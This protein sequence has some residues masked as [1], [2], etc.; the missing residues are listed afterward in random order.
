MG[1]STFII[2][3]FNGLRVRSRVF[4]QV[5]SIVIYKRIISWLDGF[6]V[7]ERKDRRSHLGKKFNRQRKFPLFI[8]LAQV[9]KWRLLWEE[10]K[11]SWILF[12]YHLVLQNFLF[13]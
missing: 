8:L 3:A 10:R 5:I 9:Y 1:E 12:S 11:D 2:R 6:F 13:F 7:L 4:M